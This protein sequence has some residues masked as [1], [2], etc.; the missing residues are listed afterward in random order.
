MIHSLE[1]YF[2]GVTVIKPIVYGNI[3]K[4]FGKKREEDG[5]THQVSIKDSRVLGMVDASCIAQSGQPIGKIF[6]CNRW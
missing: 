6:V 2:Q 1:L 4:H 3:A 5:H